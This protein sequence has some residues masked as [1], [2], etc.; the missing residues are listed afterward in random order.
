MALEPT[1]KMIV[2]VLAVSGRFSAERG[3]ETHPNGSGSKDGVEPAYTQPHRPMLRPFRDRVLV[4]TE[5]RKCKMI[6]EVPPRKQV[7]NV[8]IHN[9]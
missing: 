4:Q 1:G 3:P 8:K 6:A 9:W 7:S 2:C 5:K